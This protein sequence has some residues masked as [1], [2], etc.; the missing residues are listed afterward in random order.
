MFVIDG[1]GKNVVNLKKFFLFILLSLLAPVLHAGVNLPGDYF[2]TKPS[3]APTNGTISQLSVFRI[4]RHGRRSH[5][6]PN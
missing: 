1:P 3:L 2:W 4:F 6:L 5:D